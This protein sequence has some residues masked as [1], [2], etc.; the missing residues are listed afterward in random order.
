MKKILLAGGAGYI[1]SILAEMLLEAGYQVR[2]L[3]RFFFG[4]DSIAPLLKNTNLETI[5]EDT[6]FV[7]QDAFVV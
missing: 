5:D 6:R 7:D 4:H 1:G 3:D 2:I